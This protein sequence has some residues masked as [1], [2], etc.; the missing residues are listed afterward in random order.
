VEEEVES[1]SCFLDML[2]VMH[3]GHRLV[4]HSPVTDVCPVRLAG[5]D[6]IL[7]SPAAV[8]QLV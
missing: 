5:D 8:V 6:C 4:N 3:K 1:N 7:E 2:L